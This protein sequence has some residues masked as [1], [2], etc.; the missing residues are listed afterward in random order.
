MHTLDRVIQE[1]LRRNIVISV[2]MRQMNVIAGYQQEFC[3]E[4][5]WT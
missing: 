5:L 2:M 1:K 3:G 4:P